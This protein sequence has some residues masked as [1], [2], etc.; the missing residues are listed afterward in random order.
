VLGCHANTKVA[1][2]EKRKTLSLP[3]GEP[4]LAGAWRILDGIVD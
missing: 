4:D 1:H 3:N 2:G